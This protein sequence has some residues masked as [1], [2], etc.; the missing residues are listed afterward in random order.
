MEKI[1]IKNSI[2]DVLLS[3]YQLC[4]EKALNAIENSSNDLWLDLKN[5]WCY[6]WNAYHIIE[7]MDFYSRTSPEGMEWGKRAGI[8][9]NK[10]DKEVAEK[11]YQKITKDLVRE[12]LDDLKENV[13]RNLHNTSDSDFLQQGEFKWFKSRLERHLYSLRHAEFH[14]GELNKSLRQSDNLRIKWQ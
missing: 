12:Y 2:K 1:T 11:K 9:W 5:D 10:D 13:T 6:A 7:G 8:D 3:Q 14:I 4:W